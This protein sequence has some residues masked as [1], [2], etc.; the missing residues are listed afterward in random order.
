ML[1]R[2]CY[3]RTL[4][5]EPSDATNE[6]F[7]Y[8]LADAAAKTGVLVHAVCV[9]SNH[10]H[11]VVTDVEGRL[12]EFTRELHRQTAKAI[13]ACQ[14]LR[15]NLWSVDRCHHLE[16]ADELAVIRQ[17][18]Y[19][20]TN[21]TEAG[22][23]EMPEQWP[24]VWYVPGD[25]VHVERVRRPKS[26]F[27][28]RSSAPAEIELRIAPPPGMTDVAVRVAAAI[29]ERLSAAWAKLREAGWQFLG[30]AAILAAPRGGRATS[31][32]EPGQFVPQF[33]ATCPLARSSLIAAR[34]AFR[35][36]YRDALDRWRE[37]AR[38][39]LFPLGTWWMR[40][41]HGAVVAAPDD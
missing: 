38:E 6:I 28:E 30:R 13:N 39:V 17:I 41:F 2:R 34:R 31:V 11:L 36:A 8:C 16:L 3:Q 25:E 23:V 21:P 1:T 4:Q 26:Y 10:L 20:A 12:P 18:A 14:G 29:H 40:V 35:C 15:E 37:G 19:V 9:M 27:G 22:L 33:A 24:G 32:E 7:R 5:L